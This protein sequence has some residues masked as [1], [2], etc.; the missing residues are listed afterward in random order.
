MIAIIYASMIIYYT[1]VIRMI[2]GD[3]W[4]DSI[5][6]GIIWPLWIY[7]EGKKMIIK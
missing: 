2:L 6:S 1:L 4:E 5:Y 3:S 7:D